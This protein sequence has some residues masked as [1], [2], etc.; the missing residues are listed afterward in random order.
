MKGAPLS[1]AV[2]RLLSDCALHM[3][4]NEPFEGRTSKVALFS[5]YHAVQNYADEF[6]SVTRR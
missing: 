5:L 3:P 6:H 2:R 1:S 4:D